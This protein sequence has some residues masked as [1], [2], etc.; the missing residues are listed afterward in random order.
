MRPVAPDDSRNEA[1]EVAMRREP[2]SRTELK[3]H[4]HRISSQGRPASCSH[5][6]RPR[7]LGRSA[8]AATKHRGEA[9]DRGR[10]YLDID[11]LLH[12]L[13]Q[14]F[15]RDYETTAIVPQRTQMQ[16]AS[17]STCLIMPCNDSAMPGIGVKVVT[18]RG[19]P[20]VNGDR[21]QADCFLLEQATGKVSALLSANY[22]TEMRTAAVSAIATKFLVGPDTK[23]L[24]IF[25]TGRL[26]IAHLLLLTH[27]HRYERLLV[28]G[29]QP[30]R[31]EAFA[32]STESDHNLRVEPVDSS[33]CARER[34]LS[35][36]A[37]L[38]RY[39]CK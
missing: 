19:G 27:I 26:A 29:S 18:V 33:T 20:Q 32:L 10:D 22:L 16:V 14:M 36:R 28:C 34:T 31:S 38:R 12:V 30:S 37:L 1:R 11:E 39:Q 21:V 17:G 23:T 24:G 15:R 4:N 35:V 6:P 7:G 5:F 3:G 8:A 2:F 25:G 9:A 13:E